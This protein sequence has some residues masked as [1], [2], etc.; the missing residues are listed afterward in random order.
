MPNVAALIQG[1][2]DLGYDPSLSAEQLRFAAKRYRDVNGRRR[3]PWTE[4]VITTID[5]TASQ[6]YTTFA[7]LTGFVA[8][9]SVRITYSTTDRPPIEHLPAQELLELVHADPSPGTP[10]YWTQLDDK[11]YW[12]PIPDKAYDV[13]VVYKDT[14]TEITATNQTPVWPSTFHDIL[15]YGIAADMAA[16]ERDWESRDRW[17]QIYETKIAEMRNQI[18]LDQRQTSDHVDTSFYDGMRSRT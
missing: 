9:D 2:V 6:G 7:A 5:T 13:S 10:E 4:G 12:Y 8:F 15:T 11:I 1:A 14:P 16:R 3:W 18:V 17:E